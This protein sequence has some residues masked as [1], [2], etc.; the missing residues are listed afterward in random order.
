[1]D[2]P[3]NL[4]LHRNVKFSSLSHNTS[5]KSYGYLSSR[6]CIICQLTDKYRASLWEGN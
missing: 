4:D 1:M 5:T 3:P 2:L 6:F